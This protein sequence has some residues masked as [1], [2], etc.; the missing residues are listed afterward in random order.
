MTRAA[1][2]HRVS[3]TPP[4]EC[5]STQRL[6]EGPNWVYELKLDDF[7]AQ[8]IRDSSGIELYSKNGKDFTGKFPQ[9]VAAL[10]EALPAATAL[11][12][13]L[14]AF[15]KAGKPSFSAMQDANRDTNLEFFVFDV[16]ATQGRDLKRLPLSER[17][18]VLRSAF[19][20][21]NLV[22]HSEHFIGSLDRFKSAV[23]SIGGEGIVAKRLTS[24]YEP[25]RRSGAWLKM[26]FN[27]G[28]EFVIGGFTPGSNGIDALV[29]GY[30]VSFRQ[31]CEAC[32]CESD[33][34]AEGWSVADVFCKQGVHFIADT[35]AKIVADGAHTVQPGDQ[36]VLVSS[37]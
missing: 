17:L 12:G 21:S 28:Q 7:R 26:R 25:G 3:F 9:V 22:Q 33:S 2:E 10:K 31:E 13:E 20:S 35:I 1:S 16:L 19:T 11:D 34:A 36:S 8:A 32:L 23:R 6:P 27:V 15:D 14:V 5:L 29:V 24:P 30:Y 4:M 37:G 18:A